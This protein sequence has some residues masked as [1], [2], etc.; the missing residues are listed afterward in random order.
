MVSKFEQSLA[1]KSGRLGVHKSLF[2]LHILSNEVF[3]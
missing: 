2:L 3:V 1:Y